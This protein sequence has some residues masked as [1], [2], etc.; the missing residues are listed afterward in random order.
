MSVSDR[1]WL[2][3]SSDG[4]KGFLGERVGTTVQTEYRVLPWYYSNKFI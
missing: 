1:G 2:G 3:S 4:G